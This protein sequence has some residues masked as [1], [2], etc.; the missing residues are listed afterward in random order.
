MGF[1]K[2]IPN[3]LEEAK[4]YLKR[5]VLVRHLRIEASTV[6]EP[7]FGSGQRLQRFEG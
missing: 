4:I 7:G 2:V 6:D 3:E 5:L 1:E